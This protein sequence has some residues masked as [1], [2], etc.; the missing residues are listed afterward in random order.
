MAVTVAGGCAPVGNG[1]PVAA[2]AY[3]NRAQTDGCGPTAPGDHR[4]R[5]CGCHVVGGGRGRRYA[6][7][8][9]AVG[10][11][12][13]GPAVVPVRPGVSLG[14]GPHSPLTSR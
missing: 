14:P 13:A 2:A 1:G 5:R 6:G 4:A 3:H 8:G 11:V 7:A 12:L 10:P 9:A